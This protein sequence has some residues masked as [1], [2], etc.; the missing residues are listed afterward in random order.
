MSQGSLFAFNETR[1]DTSGKV[2]LASVDPGGPLGEE[3]LWI[4]LGRT[5]LP[6]WGP[7]PN[8]VARAVSVSGSALPHGINHG[9]ALTRGT[10]HPSLT[11]I[12]N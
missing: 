12:K 2:N 10:G 9:G 3:F 8:A 7:G 11:P 6:P 1:G 4:K 5:V